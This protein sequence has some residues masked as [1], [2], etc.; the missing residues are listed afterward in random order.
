MPGS[1]RN[2]INKDFALVVSR[3]KLEWRQEFYSADWHDAISP[4]TIAE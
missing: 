3:E 4:T 1:N 2:E